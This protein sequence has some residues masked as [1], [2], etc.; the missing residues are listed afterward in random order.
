MPNIPDSLFTADDFVSAPPVEKDAVEISNIKTSTSPGEA[1]T[2]A[3][4]SNSL[5][6]PEQLSQQDS[7]L[8]TEE[9]NVLKDR[10]IAVTSPSFYSW[11]RNNYS[12][13]KEDKD[14]LSVVD[15]LTR[16][17]GSFAGGVIQPW[18]DTATGIGA[19]YG[20]FRNSAI[21]TLT[22]P[23]RLFN[24]AFA[25]D[26]KYWLQGRD[27]GLPWWINIER[28]ARARGEG[29]EAVAEAL[30]PEDPNFVEQVIGGTGQVASQITMAILS[31]GVGSSIALFGQGTAIQ[32]RKLDETRRG[33]EA[34][35]EGLAKALGGSVT[36]VTERYGLDNLMRRIPE[37]IRT[38]FVRILAGAGSEASQEILEEVGQN[39]VIAGFDSSRVPSTN[40]AE[41]GAVAGAVGGLVS[42][43]IPGRKRSVMTEEALNN[44]SDRVKETVLNNTSEEQAANAKAEILRGSGIQNVFIDPGALLAYAA[45][46]DEGN[47]LL[48]NLRQP[49]DVALQ[50]DAPV[51]ITREDFARYVFGT[52]HYNGLSDELYYNPTAI[53]SKTAVQ[54]LKDSSDVIEKAIN[55]E[56]QGKV[57]KRR[58]EERDAKRKLKES[59]RTTEPTLRQRTLKWIEKFNKGEEIDLREILMQ[60]PGDVVATVEQYLS[61]I[62]EEG[63]L[64][65]SEIASARTRTIG[66]ELQDNQF[67]IDTLNQAI[68]DRK[69]TGKTTKR[70]EQRVN[71]LEKRQTDLKEEL[72]SF[73]PLT[74]DDLPPKQ[75]EALRAKIRSPEADPSAAV[76][77][78]AERLR[79]LNVKASKE[80]ATAVRKTFARVRKEARE[81]FRSAQ[82]ILGTFI[83]K[84]DLSLEKKGK[85]L[86]TLRKTTSLEQLE[87]ELPALQ[88]R[89]LQDVDAQRKAQAKGAIQKIVKKAAKQGKK[90]QLT[91]ALNDFVRQA[92]DVIKMTK[93][94]AAAKLDDAQPD[95]LI[96]TLLAL[97]A[98]PSRIDANQMEDL[99]LDLESVI[100]QGQKIRKAS[101][102]YRDQQRQELKQ[103]IIDAIGPIVKRRPGGVKES[104]RDA[105]VTGWLGWNGAWHNK[106]QHIF[107]SSDAKEVNQ[108]LKD[109]SLFTESRK[110]DI[111]FRKTTNS[112]VSKMKAKVNMSERAMLKQWQ[113]DNTDRIDLPNGQGSYTKA[114]IRKR[115]LELENDAIRTHLYENEGFKQATEEAMRDTL[116]PF[117]V[118]MMESQREF[119]EEYYER[120][121]EVYRKLY[122]INLPRITSYTPIRRD[123]GDGEIQDDFLR[124]ISYVGG[125]GPSALKSRTP[126]KQ[127]LQILSDVA[128]LQSHMYEMEYFI[129]YAE[130]VQDL[131]NIF[132]GS[133]NELVNIIADK[134]GNAVAN[135]IR[136]DLEYFANRGRMGSIAGERFFVQL[137]RNFTFAQLGA[138]PQ[139]G[140]KQLA[141]FSAFG[142]NVGVKNFTAGLVKLATNPAA[143]FKLMNESDFFSERGLN[144]D[145]DFRELRADA[146]NG[147]LLNFMGR[148]PN[149]TRI[150]M[151]PIRYGDKGAIF[152]GGYA[153]V[154]ARMKEGATKEEA[155]DSFARLA[156]KTQQSADPDQQSELQRTSALYRV[157]SQFMSSANAITR[158]EI[159]AIVEY[160]KGRIDTPELLKRIAIYHFLI[161]NTIMFLANGMAWD[162]DDQLAASILG[163]FTGLII[164]GD[165]LEFAARSFIG[166]ASPFEIDARHPLELMQSAI[167]FASQDWDL[168]S[169]EDFIEGSKTLERLLE[170]GGALSGVPLETLYNQLR[171]AAIAASGDVREGGGLM[172]GYSPYALRKG[173]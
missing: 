144:I 30:T 51:R 18:A 70:L 104:A 158:A 119:Y 82:T 162:G 40:L 143:A 63:V 122:G 49:L 75:R 167:K 154:Y 128:V 46:K 114:E 22:A 58:E 47:V 171:G 165:V 155:L 36:A 35:W 12:F 92:K 41:Q 88:A 38:R 81:N 120:I 102:L 53:P 57:D 56:E 65:E 79:N 109:L 31:G 32:E 146:L 66:K 62:K 1:A 101:V 67:N 127:R 156:N 6:T 3:D 42:A 25:S 94:E 43:I 85:Y 140:L 132:T 87:K 19:L 20:E 74:F 124:S 71:K 170:F 164:F 168:N 161:P 145:N 113:Q 54:E 68:E 152:I 5:F 139:I 125:V 59:I 4:L 110:H 105:F 107:E 14:E 90:G 64:T 93:A 141:S 117:D 84:S 10:A 149:F 108:L 61:D 160:R 172:I 112:F 159:E 121:N 50:N 148:N 13:G 28:F 80:T 21:D 52:D 135:T 72:D 9:S 133:N 23:I 27:S 2:N 137:M 123:Y 39:L 86:A 130:K 29:A 60:A 33:E 118:A 34:P 96:N 99:I 8:A 115:L 169:F 17:A 136:R 103:R 11:L 147:K 153:H 69:A 131:K 15:T 55:D 163:S 126:N 100:V 150:M 111:N 157:L 24:P 173:E 97:K 106:L 134:Y 77:L 16:A 91:P 7:V 138:K 129:A 89:I 45:K 95:S 73:K 151:L 48:Q 142:Q 44:A 37:N 166:D 83:E 78:R 116:N 98:D 76:T 26:M